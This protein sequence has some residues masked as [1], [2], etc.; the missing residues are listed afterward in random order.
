MTVSKSPPKAASKT[1]SKSPG[2]R[3]STLGASL[4]AHEERPPLDKWSPPRLLEFPQPIPGYRYRWIAEYVRGEY[5]PR[6]LQAAHRDGYR[7]V[8]SDQIEE[9]FFHENSED[10]QIRS[11]GLILMIIPDDFAEQRKVYYT[12]RSD[13]SLRSANELQGLNTRTMPTVVE[14]NSRTLE[15]AAALNALKSG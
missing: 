12:D 4:R 9:S 7:P 5:Q 6:S 2:T 11:G 10:G 3:A 8:Y 15:G 1:P 13:S 14:D